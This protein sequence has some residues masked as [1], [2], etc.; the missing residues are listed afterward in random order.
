MIMNIAWCLPLR[1]VFQCSSPIPP[2]KS[3][4]QNR[5][6]IIET[7][8]NSPPPANSIKHLEIQADFSY[9]DESDKTTAENTMLKVATSEVVVLGWNAISSKVQA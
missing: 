2:C 7:Q 1:L 9:S 4:T 5:A 3:L 6:A 8:T